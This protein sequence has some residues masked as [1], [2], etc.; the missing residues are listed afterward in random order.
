MATGTGPPAA[1]RLAFRLRQLRK[2]HWPDRSVTQEELGRAC[3]VSTSSI[4]SW[5]K[6]EQP[7][8]PPETRLDAYA[9]F[10]ATRRSVAGPRPRL[11]DAGA[12]DAEETATREAIYRELLGLHE[13]VTGAQLIVPEPPGDVDDD[14]WTFPDGAPIRIICG[15]LP[16]ARRSPT[17]STDDPDYVELAATAD[18]DALFELHGHLR[19]RNPSSDVRA[20]RSD[21]ADAGDMQSHVVLLGD[22]A[23]ALDW[24]WIEALPVRRVDP[25]E[26]RGPA[27]T[28]DGVPEPLHG[29]HENGRIREDVGLFA[30][31]RNPFHVTRTL[32]VCAGL[33]TRG[34]YAAVRI[35]TDGGLA[36]ANAGYLRDRAA[37]AETFGVVM[38]VLTMEHTVPTP[39]LRNPANRLFE[40]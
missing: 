5:E 38:R 36:E 12:L 33:H 30:R 37:G 15:V 17:A 35:L 27:F 34:V 20:I 16:A 9:R 14:V 7:T 32:T 21:V 25:G 3:G 39:D 18:L 40:F 2:T 28:A 10:F 29:R 22:A 13:M 23:A 19:M 4:S 8:L 11:F 31:T 1:E 24:A 26:G 6:V